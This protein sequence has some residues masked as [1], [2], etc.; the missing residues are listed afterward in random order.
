M[1]LYVNKKLILFL[2]CYAF[3]GLIVR[4]YSVFLKNTTGLKELEI[5]VKVSP[6]KTTVKLSVEAG[7][8]GS[9]L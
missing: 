8:G 9:H 3:L 1:V 7:H 2:N 6:S 5:L 4:A